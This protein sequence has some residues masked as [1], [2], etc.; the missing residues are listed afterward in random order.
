MPTII[1]FHIEIPT[2]LTAVGLPA[3]DLFDVGILEAARRLA[4]L[5]EW[6]RTEINARHGRAQDAAIAPIVEAQDALY[7]EIAERPAH[8]LAGIAVKLDTIRRVVVGEE[9]PEASAK[10]LLATVI[11][12][13]AELRVTAQIVA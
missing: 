6:A 11:A 12:A 13:A 7:W 10:A 9:G 2:S 4:A 8:T 5:T 1:P 3:D